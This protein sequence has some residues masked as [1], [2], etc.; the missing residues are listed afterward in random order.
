MSKKLYATLKALDNKCK[1]YINSTDL[2]TPR[3]FR[4]Y[5]GVS[6]H[7][8]STWKN[9]NQEYFNLI[10]MYED[11]ILAR[12][13][14]FAIYGQAHP[15]IQKQLIKESTETTYYKDGTIKSERKIWVQVGKFNA[16]GSIFTLKAY[17]KDLYNQLP[18]PEQQEQA[19]AMQITWADQSNLKLD[20][21]IKKE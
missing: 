15:V 6:K 7:L 16:N 3:E 20:H 10:K 2:W 18:T 1:D 12:V 11:M 9:T 5:I 13:E 14:Q 8:L 19:E 4:I 21:L 17:D